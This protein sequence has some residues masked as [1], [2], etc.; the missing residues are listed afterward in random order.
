MIVAGFGFR[1]AAT[2]DSLRSALI[3]AGGRADVIAAPQDKCADPAFLSFA[4]AQSLR[5]IPVS[6][7]DLVEADTLTSSARV[8]ALRGTGSVAE[9]AALAA[10]GPGARLRGPRAVSD[11]RMATCAIALGAN[12]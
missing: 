10:A 9:A 8:K 4:E 3:N 12:E 6:Q 7:A 11:D 1:A 2:G 5:I